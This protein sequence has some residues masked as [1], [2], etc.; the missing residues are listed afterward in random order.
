MPLDLQERPVKQILTRSSGYLLAVSSHSLQPYRG[1]TFGGSLCG[2]GCYVQHNPFVTQGR[3]WGTFLEVRSNAADSYER[4]YEKENR[5]T[6]RQGI[7]FVIFCSSSTDPFLPQETRF[8]ITRAVLERMLEF[9]PEGLILQTHSTA[10]V[11]QTTLLQ[12][13]ATRTQLRIHLSIEGDRDRL[14]GL[15]PPAASVEARFKACQNLRQAGLRVVVTAAPLHPLQD[16]E[17]F[18]TRISEVADAVVIDHFIEG[19]GSSDGSRTLRTPLAAAMHEVDPNCLTL[20]YRD[21]M[22]E[23]ARRVMPGRVGVGQAGFAG[24]FG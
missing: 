12:E 10:V 9:P 21:R 15:P 17:A 3:K 5:W 7:P 1:C 8:G 6:E 24:E 20:A 11:D 23:V 16:P 4:H 2:V 14:P 19:D 18:F 13:L 22:V